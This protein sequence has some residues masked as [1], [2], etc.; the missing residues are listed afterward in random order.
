[1][2]LLEPYANDETLAPTHRCAIGSVLAEAYLVAG[3]VADAR[4]TLGAALARSHA[5]DVNLRAH[6][7]TR[8]SYIELYAGDRAKA[9]EYATIG[10]SLAE[11]AC[12]YVVAVGS[13]SVLYNI[14]NDE[15]GPSE[16]LVYLERLGEC[17]IRAGNVDFHLYALVA[18]YELHVERGDVVAIERLERDLREFDLHYG[19]ASAL[20]GL[21]PSR[22]LLAAWTG[23][24]ASAYDLLAASA[25][26]Q[27]RYPDREALRWAEI[28]LYAAAAGMGSVAADA[29]QSFDVAFCADG[30]STQ[31]AVRGLILARLAASLAG[32]PAVHAA[33]AV[34][35]T[36]RMG[37]LERAVGVVV[38]AGSGRPGAGA[39]LDALDDLRRH[40]L[41]GMA[42]LFAALPAVPA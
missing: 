32:V 30:G 29:L 16:A 35:P 1:V 5:L 6:V 36:G 33:A 37:A 41:G 19:T 34:P 28:A 8:A 2:E 12:L 14:A 4:A 31:H 25:S 20:Q 38:Q 42:R 40:E 24:F 10:A 9:R 22:A 23:D 13:Y 7:F 15:I 17:A 11:N 3:R 27:H 18:A 26:Q 21:L 39:V